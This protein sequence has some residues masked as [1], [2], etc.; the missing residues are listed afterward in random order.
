MNMFLNRRYGIIYTLVMLLLLIGI[1]IGIIS[2]MYSYSEKEAFER[3]KLETAKQKE[4]IALMMSSDRE[5]LYSLANFLGTSYHDNDEYIDFCQ[6]FKS[7]GLCKDI[8][9]LTPDDILITKHG[10]SDVSGKIS[11]DEEAAKGAYISGRISD[12]TTEE[13]QI[14]RNVVPILDNTGNTKAILFGTISTEDYSDYYKNQLDMT[15]S[16]LCVL[17][18]DSGDF[19]IDTKDV[20]SQKNAT[21]LA[22]VQYKKGYTYKDFHD[23]ILA[24]KTGYTSFVANDSDE[25]LYI[26][27][28]ALGIENWRIILAQPESVVFAN[29]YS[30]V[31]FL[32]STSAIICLIILLYV[33]GI[34]LSNRKKTRLNFMAS[35]IRK[36]LLEVTHRRESLVDALQKLV[37]FA[38]SR[39]AFIS[40]S[41]TEE[42]HYMMPEISEHKLTP[43]E[44][45]YFNDK[46]LMYTAQNRKSYGV[47][48]YSTQIK[49][50]IKTK[51]EMPEFY[52]FMI[53]HKIYSVI[54]DVVINSNSTMYV[55]GVLNPKNKDISQLLDK[56][57]ACFSMA[58]YNR[59][60]LERTHKMALTDALTGVK[61]RTAFS[62][63]KKT[64][65]YSDSD[66]CCIYID[67]NELNYYNNKYGHAAGDQMLKFIGEILLN[68]FSDSDIY[69]MGG[70]EFL[71]LNKTNT[72]SEIDARLDKVIHDIEEMKYHIAI[73]CKFGLAGT[74]LEATVNEAEKMMYE[75]K[76]HYYQDKEIHK[77]KHIK[78]RNVALMETGIK[79]LDACLSVMTIR[80]MGI[81][82]VSLDKDSCVKIVAPSYF[83]NIDNNTY[84]YSVNF[85]K[86]IKD[87]VKSEYHR[88]LLTFL[89]YDILKKNFKE[90]HIPEISFERIDGEKVRLKIYCINV[91]Q[92]VSDCIWVFENDNA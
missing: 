12:I 11:F 26:Y 76:S 2:Y 83:E 77:V 81:Y 68:T 28:D 79:E 47:S 23:N 38:K 87:F 56:I 62:Q 6:N 35:E 74:S 54:Y 17:D 5:T 85:K 51:Q 4:S 15:N 73:G 52:E 80:Y 39:S 60:H 18:G 7:F 16:Y 21:Q 40:D 19:I 72:Q 20:L 9:I 70:D 22:Y 3:L 44:I 89:D 84:K 66:Y 13:R 31:S 46:L 61:N 24:G 71:I 69:R 53:S 78:N 75:N 8:G 64:N 36:D 43:D 88:A 48:L 25:F 59:K 57:A 67:V 34:A 32:L 82:F 14:I 92:S 29:V 42:C 30:T 55:I 65:N 45:K 10:M 63:D 91:E 90:K 33:I 27:Y 41:Y 49:A 58:V 1:I 50:N 86:Y 37:S